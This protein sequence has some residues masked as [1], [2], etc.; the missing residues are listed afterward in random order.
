MCIRDRFEGGKLFVNG[1]EIPLMAGAD[2][3]TTEGGEESLELDTAKEPAP[4]Q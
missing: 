3:T 4:Q 1:Q 2:Q